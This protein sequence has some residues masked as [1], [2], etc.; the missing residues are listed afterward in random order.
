LPEHK[1]IFLNRFWKS[2]NAGEREMMDGNERWLAPVKFTGSWFERLAGL[3]SKTW[4][5]TRK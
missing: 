5:W 4:L 1:K 2:R 3:D